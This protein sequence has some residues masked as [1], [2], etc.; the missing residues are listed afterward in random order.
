MPPYNFTS[1]YCCKHSGSL[2]E[3]EDAKANGPDG[4]AIKD[5][6][7]GIVRQSLTF[8]DNKYSPGDLHP[9]SNRERCDRVRRGNNGPLHESDGPPEIH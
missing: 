2:A 8:E 5:K 6:R 9:A 1:D 4:E 3:R 7:S